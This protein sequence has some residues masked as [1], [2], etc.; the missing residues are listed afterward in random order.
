MDKQLIQYLKTIIIQA[1]EKSI[2]ARKQGLKIIIKQDNSPVTNVDKEISD[3]IFEK[4]TKILPNI[5]VVC[6]ERTIQ[7]IN[8]QEQFWL[9]DPIDGTRSYI[10]N[11][12]HFTINIALIINNI[13]EYGFIYI[14]IT[15]MLYY[16]DEHKKLVI[17]KNNQIIPPNIHQKDEYIAVVSSRNM[18]ILVE[19]YLAENQLN[20]ILSIPSSIKLCLV[21]ESACDVYPKFGNTMEWDIAA[22]HALIKAT[23][24]NVMTLDDFELEYNK[25][26]FLNPSFIAANQ[27]WLM[28]SC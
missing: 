12:D 16:T 18:D 7:N 5:P 14:P 2:K 24:G 13:V 9:I 6:E 27:R 1:G 3:F 11:S 21:A 20:N 19:N 28:R 10:E 17:E 22:G 26:N 25:P 23:G 4:L 8:N 15:K